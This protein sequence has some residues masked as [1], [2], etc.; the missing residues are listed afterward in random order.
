LYAVNFSGVGRLYSIDRSTEYWTTAIFHMEMGNFPMMDQILQ[1]VD[2]YGYLV[3]FVSLCLE[4]IA[5][6]IPTEIL[7]SYVG[8]LVYQ[9]QSNWLLSIMAAATGSFTGMAVAYFIGLKLGYPFFSKYGSRLHMGPERLD[10]MS[11]SFQ[12]HGLK[13]LLI[14]CFIPGVRHISGYFSGISRVRFQSFAF[15]SAI[16]VIIWTTTFISLGKVLGPQWQLIETSAKKYM[17]LL[18]VFGVAAAIIIYILRTRREVIKA[19]VLRSFLRI[20]AVYRSQ[21]KLKLLITAA[22]VVFVIFSSLFIGIIQDFISRDFSEFNRVSMLIFAS[23]FNTEWSH[24]MN[25]FYWLSSIWILILLSTVTAIW[26]FVKGKSH[27]FLELRILIVL[28]AG[29]IVY[30]RLMHYIF[31]HAVQWIHWSFLRFP[32]FPDNRLMMSVVIYGFF[33]FIL[34]RHL[35]GFHFKMLAV[36]FVF[37]ALFVIGLARVYFDL[38]LPSG[39]AAGYVFG[40]VWVSFVIMLLEIFRLIK[41]NFSARV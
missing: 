32:A 27:R 1:W 3:L 5:L 17:V 22:A 14:T 37:S 8:F 38:Q 21:R 9:H 2:Q 25:I 28:L 6:P 26:I 12:K 24:A 16:G 23:V 13:L 41:I 40:G 15:F 29:G 31:D 18:I 20:N 7:M 33:A 11:V 36:I 10:K 35:K 34:S 30:T 19:A 4:L 39:V